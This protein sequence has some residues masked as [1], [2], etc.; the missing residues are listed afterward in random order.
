MRVGFRLSCLISCSVLRTGF[1]SR[2]VV[3]GDEV[4]FAALFFAALFFAALVFVEVLLVPLL[5]ALLLLA[6][7][8]AFLL[9]AFLSSFFE[10]DDWPARLLRCVF[11]LGAAVA[12]FELFRLLL[13][14]FLDGFLLDGMPPV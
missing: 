1:L 2:L 6:L 12:R 3:A 13:F 4:F 11:V 7:P 8:R 9:F 14:F 10:V 5:F